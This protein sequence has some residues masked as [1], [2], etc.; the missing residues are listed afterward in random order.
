MQYAICNL[1]Y[2]AKANI[3]QKPIFARSQFLAKA[4]DNANGKD[5]DHD[6]D[7]DNGNGNEKN[8]HKG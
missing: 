4:N 2:L 3:W 8:S 1:Q 6:H 5:N 7:N